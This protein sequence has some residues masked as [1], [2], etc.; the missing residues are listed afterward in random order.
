MARHEDDM[1][2]AKGTERRYQS[3]SLRKIIHL[4]TRLQNRH[5]DSLTAQQVETI[6]AEVG[7]EPAFVRQALSHLDSKPSTVKTGGEKAAE[8]RSLMTALGLPVLAASLAF[9]GRTNPDLR[10]FYL[11]MLPAPL[12]GYCGFLSGKKFFGV[13]I[14]IGLILGLSPTFY[15]GIFNHLQG[16]SGE[17]GASAMFGTLFY[18]V[19]GPFVTGGLGEFGAW[20]RQQYFPPS[21]APSVVSRQ[22]LLDQLYTLKSQLEGQKQHRAFLSID[23]VNSSQ[24]TRSAEALPVEYSF[25]RYKSWVEKTVKNFGGELH[26]VAGDGI[27]SMFPEG[28]SAVRAAYQLQQEIEQFNATQNQLPMPFQIRCG[29]SAG[30]VPAVEGTDIQALQS[31]IIYRAAALQKQAEPGDIVV[32]EEV[33]GDA[34]HILDNLSLLPSTEEGERAFSWKSVSS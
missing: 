11:F 2:E 17:P 28:A 34:L 4:A 7:L 8:F 29:V 24:M 22:D 27:M 15:Y 32:G 3:N 18:V 10:N 30:D 9:I 12:A 33:A 25:N 13:M 16:L 21:S 19:L 26:G 5:E 20:L 6:G 23:V 14:G 31:P 1:K